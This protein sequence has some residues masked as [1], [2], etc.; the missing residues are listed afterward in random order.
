MKILS[1]RSFLDLFN[2]TEKRDL[3]NVCW[4][5]KNP[6]ISYTAQKYLIGLKLLC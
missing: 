6:A 2:N 5:S 4:R 1:C 3:Q